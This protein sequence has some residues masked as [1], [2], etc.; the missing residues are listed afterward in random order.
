LGSLSKTN[1]RTLNLIT[2]EFVSATNNNI[3]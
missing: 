3:H 2:M 1:V